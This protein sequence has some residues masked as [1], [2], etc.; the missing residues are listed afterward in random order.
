[1]EIPVPTVAAA[2]DL[3]RRHGVTTILN[4]APAT[5]LPR[6]LLR[7]VDILTPNQ[8]EARVLAGLAP[9]DPGR[10]GT[11]PRSFWGKVSAPS[12]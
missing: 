11:S 12:S 4:P 3:G 1:M 9:D 6:E 8:T 2:L 5:P 10:T 7:R